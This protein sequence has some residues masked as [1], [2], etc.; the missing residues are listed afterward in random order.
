MHSRR[1]SR[2]SST[3]PN[4]GRPMDTPCSTR[5]VRKAS[6]HCSCCLWQTRRRARSATFIRRS[7]S[8][9]RFPRMAGRWSTLTNPNCGRHAVAQPRRVYSTVSTDGRVSPDSQ[10]TARLPSRV[11]VSGQ[12]L[13]CTD[14]RAIF[15]DRCRTTPTIAFGTPTDR[16]VNMRHDRISSEMRDFDVLPDGRLIITTAA[17]SQDPNGDTSTQLRVVLN[18]VEELKQRVPVK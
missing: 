1:H 18:W 15:H 7:Q 16:P 2:M 6:T 3:F 10:G 14:G 4:R 11:V 5:C 9:R 8:T 13:V 17:T 12:A